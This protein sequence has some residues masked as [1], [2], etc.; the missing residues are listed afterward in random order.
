MENHQL[1]ATFGAFTLAIGVVAGAT[2]SRAY[3]VP[4]NPPSDNAAPRS[5][6][7]GASRSTFF[8]PPTDAPPRSA[9][10]G[11]SRGRFFTPPAD[12]AAPRD[13]SGGASRD[14]FF[15]PP[16]D[17]AT[18]RGA[19]GGASRDN[20]FMP[21]TDNAAPQGA[22][23]GASRG[24][25]AYEGETI[26]DA[27]ETAGADNDRS[28]RSNIYGMTAS[29]IASMPSMLAVAPSSFYGTT[30]EAQPTILVYVPA[31][32]IEV[33]TFSLKNEA[34][35]T[36]Y[37]TTVAVPAR[38]G[39]MAVKMPANAPELAVGEN[40]QWYLA[41][42]VDGSLTPASPFVDGWVKR[43]APDQELLL[44]LDQSDQ[45]ANI[46]LLGQQGI[47][48]DTVAQLAELHTSQ[49]DEAIAGHWHEL[50]ESVGLAEISSEPIAL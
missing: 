15:S 42:Q 49:A 41:L 30:L 10:G 9:T 31:S 18:P 22:S 37:Q 36:I 35:D 7:G 29:A 11:A 44:A 46:E 3:A 33:A 23:G 12:S 40:Y 13:A 26:E 28:A 1:A 2:G 6:T 47:W 38:G 17:N 27:A 14:S 50:L 34:K 19:F 8:T 25:L 21:P 24:D 32:D 5:T 4:F 16:V 39:I 48:Y 43:I 20:F 45:L